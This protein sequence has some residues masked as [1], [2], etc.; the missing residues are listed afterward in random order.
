M[1]QQNSA[2]VEENA[3]ACRLLQDQADDMAARMGQFRV[4]GVTAS[5][6]IGQKPAPEAGTAREALRL[7]VHPP[8]PH[9]HCCHG[10][11]GRRGSPPVQSP[12]CL[13]R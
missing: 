2:L 4:D 3:A 11:A 8:A 7:S 6:K 5:T 13:R 9:P 10:R 1:T 12:D